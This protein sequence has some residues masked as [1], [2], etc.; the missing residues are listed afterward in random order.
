MRRKEAEV[1]E[2]R[3][4]CHCDCPNPITTPCGKI[5][6][7]CVAGRCQQTLFPVK[8][9]TPKEVI[10][11]LKAN[12]G[13]LRHVRGKWEVGRLVEI[14]PNEYRFYQSREDSPDAA[15]EA[16][17]SKIE[18]DNLSVQTSAPSTSLKGFPD[19]NETD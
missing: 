7:D 4:A 9:M 15:V 5:C 18:S 6:A 11:W 14:A 1:L 2:K 8:G 17:Q 13:S 3:C 19:E 16:I 12:D 10:A